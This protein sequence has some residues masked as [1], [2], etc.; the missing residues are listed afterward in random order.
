[1]AIHEQNRE[2][3]LRD[4]TGFIF[5]GEVMLQGQKVIVGFRRS[6]QAAFYF[7]EDP[8]FQLNS[9]LAVRRVYYGGSVYRAESGNLMEMRRC[10]KGGRVIFDSFP[11]EE[12]KVSEILGALT[13]W[14][15]T[16]RV[17]VDRHDWKVVGEGV[18]EFKIRLAAYMNRL[19]TPIKIGEQPGLD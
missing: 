15:S 9:S 3:L 8:V 10:S 13:Q 2:D 11:L 14:L 18:E 1:M 19:S 6:N 17:A 5:R 4:G 12:T 7:G 16:L